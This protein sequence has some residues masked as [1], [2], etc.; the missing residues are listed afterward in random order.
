MTAIRRD[1]KTVLMP[2]AASLNDAVE[3]PNTPT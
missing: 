3:N 1:W 2:C